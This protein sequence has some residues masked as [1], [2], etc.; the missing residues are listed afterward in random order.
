M[1]DEPPNITTLFELVRASVDERVDFARTDTEATI[2]KVRY[3]AAVAVYLNTLAVTDF[4]GRL[5][6]VRERGLVEQVIGAAFQTY[7]GADPHPSAFDKAAML[8]RGITQG[9]PF[10]D[11]NKRTRFLVA[12]YFLDL[13]GFSFPLEFDFEEAERLCLAVSA[14][15]IRDV[16]T[17]AAELERLWTGRDGDA[18]G[19]ADG[20]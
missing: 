13:V 6:P 10:N 2:A 3:L 16:T 15:E 20:S 9:H 1:T 17:I 7:A 11:G 18:G 4:G 14:G 12:A 19:S 5:G 8:L